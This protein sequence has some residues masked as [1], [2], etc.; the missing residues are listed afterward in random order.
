MF[1]LGLNK[2]RILTFSIL[3]VILI[4]IFRLQVVIA[5]NKIICLFL[6]N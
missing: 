2:H 4:I 3:V 1:K 6:T 5:L